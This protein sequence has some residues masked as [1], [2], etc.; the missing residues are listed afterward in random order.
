MDTL[1]SRECRIGAVEHKQNSNAVRR[2][3]SLAMTYTKSYRNSNIRQNVVWL[4]RM[5]LGVLAT[6]L[7]L[8]SSMSRSLLIVISYIVALYSR[9]SMARTSLGT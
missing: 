2:Q 7:L 3:H 9:T 5:C 4:D 1:I 6:F 8:Y